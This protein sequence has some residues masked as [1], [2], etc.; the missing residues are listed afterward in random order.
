MSQFP[1][2]L[3]SADQEISQGAEDL[4]NGDKDDPDDFGIIGGG[5]IFDA[6]DQSRNPENRTQKKK[7]R[8]ENPLRPMRQPEGE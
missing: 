4:E 6:T 7:D 2:P 8:D 1:D 5:L 3:R